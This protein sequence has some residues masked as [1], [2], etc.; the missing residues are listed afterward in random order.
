MRLGKLSGAEVFER[1]F[2]SDVQA[3]GYTL[4]PIHAEDALPAG[5]LTGEH[6]DPFDR[7]IAA[8]ALAMDIPVIRSDSK[9]DSFGI[10]RI[11]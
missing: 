6:R 1:E 9:L 11:W 8:Q 3:A 7:I 2:L 4:A 5:R 10:R